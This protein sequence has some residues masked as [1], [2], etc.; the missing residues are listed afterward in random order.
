MSHRVLITGA[1]GY[2]GG[3]LLARIADA[4]LPIYDRLY[5]LVRTEAQ[6]D[7]VK[8]Y[9][10]EPLTINIKDEAAVR[11]AVVGNKITI[12]F[13]LIDAFN[14]ASQRNFIKSLAEVKSTTG[15]DV[16]FLHVS[17]PG[18][19]ISAGLVKYVQRESDPLFLQTTGAK[20]FSSH[21]GAPTDRPLL[22]D[23]A[24]LYDI[25]KAQRAPV[26]PAQPVSA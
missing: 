25:Q 9:G 23:E 8:K 5:A 15:K 13:F 7:A 10:A 11:E 16:H 20:I 19:I 4:N 1:S 17:D 12:V 3:S 2:L 26:T 22:D 24:G 18:R 21:T 6:A 14:A